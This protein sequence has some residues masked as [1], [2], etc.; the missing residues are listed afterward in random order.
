MNRTT[1]KFATVALFLIAALSLALL[2]NQNAIT[3]T[4][5]LLFLAQGVLML[6]DVRWPKE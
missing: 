3:E 6:A 5:K 1:A 4:I 2:G